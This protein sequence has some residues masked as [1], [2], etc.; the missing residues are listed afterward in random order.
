MFESGKGRI[1]NAFR[2][3]GDCGSLCID[4]GLLI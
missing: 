3:E 4:S 1:M 2:E